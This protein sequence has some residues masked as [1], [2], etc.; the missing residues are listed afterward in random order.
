MYPEITFEAIKRL[1]DV[2]HNKQQKTIMLMLFSSSLT[3]DQIK[4][5][6]F[7][8]VL[9]ACD[10][11]FTEGQEKTIK[12]LTKFK[13]VQDNLVPLFD[14]S[15]KSQQRLAC[16]TPEATQFLFWHI[17]MRR[18]TTFKYKTDYVFVTNSGK[19]LGKSFITDLF[20]NSRNDIEIYDNCEFPNITAKDLTANFINICRHCLYGPKSYY[21]I[22]LIEGARN[23]KSIEAFYKDILENRDLFTNEYLKI[24]NI[25][26]INKDNKHD[27]KF[28]APM[29]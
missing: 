5:L 17:N 3:G 14:T 10:H 28:D 22:R 25:F 19:K 11:F 7:D 29:E 21:I 15:T 27:L 8:D 20:L 18:N 12:N 13:P 16:C 4:N 23:N 24:S 1:V 9:K 26:T 2:D 6:K